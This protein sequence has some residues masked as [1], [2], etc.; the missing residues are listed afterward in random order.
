MTRGACLLGW[1]LVLPLAGCGMFKSEIDKCYEEREYQQ[2]R[3]G[4]RLRVPENLEPMP[5]DAWIPIP[6][7]AANTT[8][9]PDGEPCLI[10]PPPYR[11]GN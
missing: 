10:E 7:G 4:P 6:Y 2:A 5:E 11:E 1:L 3:P 9:T 8:P